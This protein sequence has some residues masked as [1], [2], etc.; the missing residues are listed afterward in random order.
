MKKYFLNLILIYKFFY[1]LKCD[2]SFYFQ[3]KNLTLFLTLDISSVI[4]KIYQRIKDP[5][6]V[7]SDFYHE[8]FF[9]FEE[10]FRIEI[11]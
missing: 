6:G 11:D 4:L 9:K 2:Y 1:F 7:S 5:F 8:C 3:I 10:K